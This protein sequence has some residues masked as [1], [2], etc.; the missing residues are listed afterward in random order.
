MRPMQYSDTMELF[1]VSRGGG[2]SDV[3][4]RPGGGL[5]TVPA[6]DDLRSARLNGLTF[7]D[8]SR[9][10]WGGGPVPLWFLG[11][12]KVVWLNLRS[13]WGQSKGDVFRLIT[14]GTGTDAC[15]S[16]GGAATGTANRGGR[17]LVS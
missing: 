11:P 16:L 7:S 15:W 5:G 2:G 9:S 13:A 6:S 10:T 4:L 1:L 14:V 17:P 12:S 8:T 3:P